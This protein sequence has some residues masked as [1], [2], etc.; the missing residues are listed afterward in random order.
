MK[1]DGLAS[2]DLAPVARG[3]GWA[4]VSASQGSKPV[5]VFEIGVMNARHVTR[6]WLRSVR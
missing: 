1:A 3:I 4:W 5:D 6:G 2:F